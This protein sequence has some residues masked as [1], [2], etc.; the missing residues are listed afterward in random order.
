MIR[1][2]LAITTRILRQLRHDRRTLAMVLFMPTILMSIL[3][4]IFEG[5]RAIY[6]LIAPMM[7]GIIPFILMFIIA[8]VAVL[9]ERTSGTLERLM[10]LP[11][12]KFE[13]I[14][15]YVLAFAILALLQAIIVSIITTSWLEVEIAGSI[16]SLLIL[17]GV[18]GVLGMAFGL[19]FSAFARTEFQAVQFM[20]AFVFPQFLTC[21]LLAPKDSMPE[22][23][24]YFANIMPL[25]YIVEGMQE[26]QSS[27]DW[28]TD[29]SSIVMVLSLFLVVAIALG[30]KSLK[31]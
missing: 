15:G 24:Q 30:A 19:F 10:T 20:P 9:R 4:F 26:I 2:I 1:R 28:T 8:S 3:Y 23:L 11:I 31:A 21:G 17:A 12:T 29:L 16:A 14:F 22:L 6:H 25:T 13:I 7:L 18:S 27:S 5:N